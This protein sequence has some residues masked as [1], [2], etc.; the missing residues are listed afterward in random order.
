[1]REE[2]SRRGS[3]NVER[4]RGIRAGD[5]C[6][7]DWRMAVAVVFGQTRMDEFGMGS[8]SQ[9]VGILREE[10]VKNPIDREVKSGR[11]VWRVNPCWR[12]G[13]V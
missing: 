7:I 2:K 13:R 3:E 1:M 11:L 12:A 8:H 6:S 10:T 5:S 9:N 4:E